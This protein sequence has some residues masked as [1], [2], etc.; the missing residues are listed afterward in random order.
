[1]SVS[2][3]SSETSSAT[4][5]SAILSAAALPAMFACLIA[6]EVAVTFS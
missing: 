4:M 2:G 3:M 5:F 1:M 6:F